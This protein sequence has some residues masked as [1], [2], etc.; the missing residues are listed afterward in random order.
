MDGGVV[1]CSSFRDQTSNSLV[2]TGR[3]PPAD[4]SYRAFMPETIVYGGT[5]TRK[6]ASKN[7]ASGKTIG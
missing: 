6:T 5:K 3:V 4:R 7:C 1:T 2:S